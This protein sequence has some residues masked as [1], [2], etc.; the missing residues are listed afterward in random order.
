MPVIVQLSDLHILQCPGEQDQIFDSLV[1]ALGRERQSRGRIDLIAVTGDVFDSSGLPVDLAVERFRALHSAILAR[2]GGTVPCVIVPGNH[3]RRHKGLLGP[4]RAEL[5]EALERA[6]LPGVFVHGNTTPFLAAVVPPELHGLPACLIAYDSCHIERGM[7][8]AG[9]MLRQED[10]LYAASQIADH[11]P[12]WP[13][14]FLLHHHLV[15]TPLTDLEEIEAKEAAWPLRILIQKVLP[16]IVAFADR[17]ELTMT[18]LGS[19]TALST[20][21]ALGRAVL[22]LHGHKHYATAR[23]LSGTRSEQ[24]DVLVVSAGSS[25]TAQSLQP[26]AREAARLWPSFNVIAF[27]EAEISAETVGFGWKDARR[28]QLAH[29]PLSLT[30]RQGRRLKQ[31]PVSDRARDEEGPKLLL[32][33]CHYRLTPSPAHGSRRWD[34]LCQRTVEPENPNDPTFTYLETIEGPKGARLLGESGRLLRL[35]HSIELGQSR[36]ARYRMRGGVHRTI[37]DSSGSDHGHSA[38]FARL[39]LMNRYRS[40][41]AELRVTGLGPLAHSAFA[42]ATDL[43]T[44]LEQPIDLRREGDEGTVVVSM[45]DCPSRT[46]LRVY[47]PLRRMP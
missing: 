43:G 32:N 46:L 15:P 26:L 7:F 1:E 23:L 2:V 18:A 36:T 31:L 34:Y 8:S 30:R 24:G 9:G 40:R 4:H 41:R 35:P 27:N 13:V 6:T 11:D 28:G 16:E 22:V 45:H 42:S 21:H 19:G 12:S 10:L 44:G 3:D 38:P 47:W 29:R 5:F 25:G 17:E 37:V 39:E 20:L 14:V 33:Q